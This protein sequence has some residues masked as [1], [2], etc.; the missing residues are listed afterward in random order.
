MYGRFDPSRSQPCVAP[1]VE[2]SSAYV[3]VVADKVKAGLIDADDLVTAHRETAIVKIDQAPQHPD[4]RSITCRQDHGVKRLL[5]IVYEPNAGS[6]EIGHA[7]FQAN[8][9]RTQQV[10][11]AQPDQRH[12]RTGGRER[13]GQSGRAPDKR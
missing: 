9:S 5:R 6:C 12:I 4:G 1:D 8:R 11:Y 10:G 13:S 3:V 7:S 2:Q